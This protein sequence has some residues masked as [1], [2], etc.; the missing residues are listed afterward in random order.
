LVFASILVTLNIF[1]QTT[2]ARQTDRLLEMIIEQD[3]IV[4]QPRGSRPGGSPSREPG[5]GVAPEM[6]RAGRFFY[7]KYDS[8]GNVIETHYEMMFDFSDE[9]AARY[10]SEALGKNKTKGLID[11]FQY[12]AA[13]KRYG[14]IIVFAERGI[15]TL[16]L[17]QLINISLWVAGG[18]CLIVFVL[19]LLFSEWAVSP[20][21]A[22]FEK[23]RR[24]I[25]D[26]SHELKTPLTILNANADVLEHEIGENKRLFNIKTQS[27]R[28]SRL[29]RDLLT[30]A[31]TD[32]GK[33]QTVYG[34]FDISGAVLGTALEF[35]SRAFEENKRYDIDVAEGIVYTGD[36]GQIKR[37]V[38][39]LIDNAI[40]HSERNGTI[41]VSLT[42][43]GGGN[44]VISVHNTGAGISDDEKEKV[45]DRFY[46]SDESRSRDTGGYGL[47]LSIAKSIADAHKGK[48]TIEGA[49]GKW[50]KF[51]V[52]L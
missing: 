48:I 35:E 8:A 52:I 43:G 25:S 42:R 23:Q 27:E 5:W 36:A 44:P 31:K 26:A 41:Q 50:V 51:S 14:K 45:F 28:M 2:S 39:I 40:N 38:S 15:E 1:M 22:A 33:A 7:V 24:F 3:G 21:K 37:L 4:S 13:E 46:R 47:G 6:M 32:D 49:A 12:A 11:S 16:M 20:V 10:A 18:A 34:E 9:D 29:I 17:T 30:L 19:S